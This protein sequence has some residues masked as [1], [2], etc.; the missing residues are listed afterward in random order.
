MKRNT[1][2]LLSSLNYL[3][4]LLNISNQL[5]LKEITQKHTQTELSE[6]EHQQKQNSNQI[7]EACDRVLEIGNKSYE[8]NKTNTT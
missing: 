3:L 6:L 7:K 1:K 4:S 2:L 8:T 5:F